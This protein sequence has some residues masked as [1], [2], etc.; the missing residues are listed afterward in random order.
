MCCLRKV[1]TSPELSGD[2]NLQWLLGNAGDLS[3][4][5]RLSRAGC[6][7][8]RGD[9]R[10]RPAATWPWVAAS[11][12]LSNAVPGRKIDA[13]RTPSIRDGTFQ[14]RTTSTQEDADTAE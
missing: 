8:S 13:Q 3:R 7:F 9:S 4:A 2:E 1:S 5:G 14:G 12:V 11:S 10:L 6:R